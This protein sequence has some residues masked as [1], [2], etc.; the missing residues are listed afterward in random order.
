MSC[1][2]L[3]VSEIQV[4]GFRTMSS[5]DHSKYLGHDNSAP[6]SH[7]A[8]ALV[9]INSRRILVGAVAFGAIISTLVFVIAKGIVMKTLD[10]TDSRGEDTGKIN[11]LIDYYN[12]YTA[13]VT[14][15][16]VRPL[17]LLVSMVLP[18]ALVC[19]AT[20]TMMGHRKRR[21]N[22]ALSIV[23]IVLLWLLSNGFFAANIQLTSVR[24]EAQ[25]GD[26][27]LFMSQMGILSH[28][29][30]FSTA[31]I[32]R[33]SMLTPIKQK[34]TCVL[35]SPRRLPATVEFGF[36]SNTWL[37]DLLPSAPTVHD[38]S[39]FYEL[40]VA[41][42]PHLELPMDLKSARNLL[43]Y[44]LQLSDRFLSN[45]TETKS[46]D[47][48]Q[49]ELH[50]ASDCDQAQRTDSSMT[51]ALVSALN[52]TT[53]ALF[54]SS[55]FQDFAVDE[56]L[57]KF[58]RLQLSDDIRFDA[59]TLDIPFVRSFLRRRI[60]VENDTTSSEIYGGV[61]GDGV[62]EINPKEECAGDV[63]VISPQGLAMSDSAAD[64]GS[65]VKALSICVDEDTEEE[66]RAATMASNSS[67]CVRRSNSSM[68]VFSFAKRIAGDAI[69]AQLNQSVGGVVT[70]TNPRR[71]YTVTIGRLSW[72]LT[73]IADR[74]SAKCF[75][76]SGCAG[77]TFPLE[78][79]KHLVL[80]AGYLRL[81]SLSAF[82]PQ[83]RS[84]TALVDSNV[85]ETDS[86]GVLKGDFVFPRNF[87][88]SSEWQRIDGDHCEL[89]RGNLLGSVEQNH[90]YSEQPLE[91]AYMSALFWLFQNASVKNDQ[92]TKL[93]KPTLDFVENQFVRDARL[94]IPKQSA[95]ITYAGC[96]LLVVLALSILAVGKR[97][98]ERIEAEFQ[99]RHLAMALLGVDAFASRWMTTEL[100]RVGSQSLG[101]SEQLHEFEISGLTL[102]HCSQ[103][104]NVVHIPMPE[105]AV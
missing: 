82:T 87:Q 15:L 45:Q 94:S 86:S 91:P 65:Q 71:Y 93:Q 49:Y 60:T 40:G 72:N 58:T 24:I 5:S 73:D 80:G 47:S 92:L 101:S 78:G 88:D 67:A 44:S 34:A 74:F 69:G 89:E 56:V 84:W 100:L 31:T 6:S 14:A 77:L 104:G 105:G 90:L 37:R 46:F 59:V 26:R 28:G 20:R 41:A 18:V 98:E 39:V 1:S 19:L 62:F 66:D 97:S 4:D 22:V 75:A 96:L 79:N 95:F 32:L 35:A 43:T 10:V 16:C 76:S 42:D 64:Y 54:N 13:F 68:L 33:T 50:L 81:D 2:P 63:C 55:Q 3:S 29:S 52:Q 11:D 53:R 102:R 25:V 57:V 103:R 70:L 7:V 9:R 48:N 8:P 51:S 23:S 27:D 99:P 21:T 38:S 12:F 17:L 61:L 83:A 85:Q 36:P 30:S